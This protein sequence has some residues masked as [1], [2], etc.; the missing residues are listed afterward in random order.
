MLYLITG[1][2]VFAV[3]GTLSHEAGHY[4][5]A[6]ALGYDAKISYA[7][8]FWF[9][10]DTTENAFVTS[11]FEKYG[12]LIKKEKEFPEKEK[13]LRI[14][15]KRNYDGF[16]ITLWG[17]LQTML[18]GTLG[19]LLIIFFRKSFYTTNQ[20]R[21]WQW[22]L[23]F[24]SLFWL[25]QICNIVMWTGDYLL[26]GE[27]RERMD[28]IHIANHFHLP[29]G[30]IIGITALISVIIASIVIFKFIPLIQRKTFIVSGLI[31]GIIGYVLWIVVLGP[32][33]MP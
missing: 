28:E 31:G 22:L 29:I 8:T 13:F 19:F 1:F 11:V 16:W 15:H 3:I 2:I 5:A 18:T 23:V 14:A 17:P 12:N 24:F 32:V 21:L 25:R 30:T 7:Y 6:K 27:F 20:L 4:F 26:K 33:V 9:N 10:K